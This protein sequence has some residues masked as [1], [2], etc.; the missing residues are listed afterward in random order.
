MDLFLYIFCWGK[1]VVKSEIIG[2]R[3][4]VVYLIMVKKFY[5]RL[6]IIIKDFLVVYFYNSWII[7]RFLVDN[8]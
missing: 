4:K 3:N 5:F 2:D 1:W 6:W 8:D 7:L